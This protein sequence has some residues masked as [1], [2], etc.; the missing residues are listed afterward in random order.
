VLAVALSLIAAMSWGAADFLG[1]LAARGRALVAVM[2]VSQ[3]AGLV[4]LLAVGLP[5][6][7]S[8]P[9]FADLVPA[10]AGGV[11]AVVGLS[12]LYL[13][14]AIGTMSVVAPIVALSAVVPVA[15]S[16]AGGDE[17]SLLVAAGIVLAL[18]GAVGSA[19]AAGEP[20]AAAAANRVRSLWFA[21][22]AAIGLGLGL[23]TLD[24]AA[25]SSALWTAMTAR[26]CSVGVVVLAFAFR[27]APLGLRAPGIERVALVGILDAAA[28]T[29]FALA[30]NEGLLAVVSVLA[31]LY[32]V[33]TVLL[34]RAV[35]GERMRGVQIAGVA[36]AFVGIGLIAGGT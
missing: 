2:L 13:A 14:L 20:T 4:V 29:L 10:I 32:P 7:G 18:G 19:A 35:L 27:P 16:L 12:L 26:T 17:L 21:A 36:V 3:A 8:P 11:V 25:D 1:G 33:V 15:V 30:S 24:A 34:A 31:S 6:A 22:G 28:L 5:L 23:V 9:S